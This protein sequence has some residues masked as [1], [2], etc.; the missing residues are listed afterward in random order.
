[1]PSGSDFRALERRNRRETVELVLAF[2][3]LFLVL[4]AAFDFFAGT[5]QF[6]D[7]H[8]VGAP[9]FMVLALIFALIQSSISYFGGAPLILL[10]VH[11]QPN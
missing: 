10:S 9:V 5:L 4:G 1:M 11:A 7:G 8:L 2:I 3:V 6:Y